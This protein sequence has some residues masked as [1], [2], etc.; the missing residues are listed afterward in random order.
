MAKAVFQH[1][2]TVPYG[3]LRFR[4]ALV[5]TEAQEEY[6]AKI[7]VMIPERISAKICLSVGWQHQ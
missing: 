3:D 7:A 5:K 6:T 2:P 4:F 1:S